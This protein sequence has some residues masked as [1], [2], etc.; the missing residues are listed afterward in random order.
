MRPYLFASVVILM[1]CSLFLACAETAS[2]N[3]R[4]VKAEEGSI[5]Y[6]RVVNDHNHPIVSE[7][8]WLGSVSNMALDS[9]PIDPGDS[10]EYSLVTQGVKRDEETGRMFVMAILKAKDMEKLAYAKRKTVRIY[11]DSVAVFIFT[12]DDFVWVIK[13]IY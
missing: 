9:L 8:H 6:W 5:F 13:V 3:Y 12:A 2:L 10:R 7:M 11:S 1:F 4:G